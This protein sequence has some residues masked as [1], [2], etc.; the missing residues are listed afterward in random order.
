MAI[1]TLSSDIGQQDFIVAA[2]KGQL[3][4][5]NN[6]FTLVDITHQLL[7][8]NYPQATYICGNAIKHFPNNSFHIVL[9]DCFANNN[10]FLLA[11]HN[12]Q[13]I[14]CA[15]NGLLTM[16]CG[17]K[18]NTIISLPT[19]SGNLLQKTA[20]IANAI[21]GLVSGKAI[22]NIGEITNT[23]VEKYSLRAI[24][25]DNWIDAQILYIDAFE[26]VVVN[27]NEQEFEEYR[28]GRNFKLIFQRQ[29]TI[30]KISASYAHTQEGE[31]LAWFNSAGYLELA[32][33]R[34]NMAG[35]FGLQG[36]NENLQNAHMHSKL[37]YQTIRIFFE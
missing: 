2:I 18:P 34:G 21:Q 36:Y 29:E 17:T 3:L 20:I 28:D 24:V 33:N 4:H 30:E 5:Y 19:N 25:T 26:N 12:N 16:L 8:E 1:V 15:D 23:I 14:I 32:L 11:Y 10:P 13:F 37:Y 22:Q 6:A 31:I 9:L 35:L 7:K 27:I